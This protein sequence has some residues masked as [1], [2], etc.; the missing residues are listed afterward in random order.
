[1]PRRAEY[2]E[3]LPEKANEYHVIAAGSLLGTLLAAPKFFPWP[4]GMVNLLELMPLTFDE[5][6]DA[7]DLP[8]YSYYTD[9]QK[10]QTIE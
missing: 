4:V 8:L 5:F 2:P 3:I 6:L 10:E 7:I 1:M 9:I